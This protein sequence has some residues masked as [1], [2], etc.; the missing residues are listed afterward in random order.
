MSEIHELLLRA[1]DQVER[2]KRLVSYS[3]RVIETVLTDEEAFAA[4]GGVIKPRSTKNLWQARWRRSPLPPFP[5]DIFKAHEIAMG[6]VGSYGLPVVLRL[7]ALP[8]LPFKFGDATKAFAEFDLRGKRSE[9]PKVRIVDS[10]TK[11]S[12]SFYFYCIHS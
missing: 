9:T 3:G 7:L 12:L 5:D 11:Y 1:S 4:C 10:G 6:C 2:P 8:P